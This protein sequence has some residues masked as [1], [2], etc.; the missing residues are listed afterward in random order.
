MCVIIIIII[1]IIL[2]LRPHTMPALT[3]P[4]HIST[5][6]WLGRFANFLHLHQSGKEM[7]LNMT[8]TTV[9]ACITAF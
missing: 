2:V 9:R 1:I 6:A 4:T 3:R 7:W 5:Q 8:P